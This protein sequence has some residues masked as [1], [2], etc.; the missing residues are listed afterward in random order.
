MLRCVVAAS[1]SPRPRQVSASCPSFRSSPTVPAA[2]GPRSRPRSS[3]PRFPTLPPLLGQPEPGIGLPTARHK[4]LRQSLQVKG[5][6]LPD[7]LLNLSGAEGRP[8]EPASGLR[9]AVVSIG[10]GPRAGVVCT[11]HTCSALVRLLSG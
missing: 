5:L 2:R 7:H 6:V 11:L 9:Y 10:G 4:A 8:I 1:R 3:Y